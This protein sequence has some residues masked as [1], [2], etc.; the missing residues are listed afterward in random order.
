MSSSVNQVHYDTLI[1]IAKQLHSES[2]DH[3]RL[4][5]QTRQR[6]DALQGGGWQGDAAKAFFNEMN[7]ELLPAS[8]R[9]VG[10]LQT[11][12]SVLNQIMQIIHQADEETASNFKKFDAY[13]FERREQLRNEMQARYDELIKAGRTPDT[14]DRFD[15]E[16][17]IGTVLLNPTNRKAI[18]DMAKKYGIDPALLTG[19]I[20]V[21]MDLDYKPGLNEVQDILGRHFSPLKNVLDAGLSPHIGDLAGK[22]LASGGPGVGNV[23]DHSLAYAIQYL[24]DNHLPGADA[25]QKYDWSPQNR[26]SFNGSVE[27]AAIVLSMYSHMHGGASSVD[28]MAVIWGAY[29]SGIEGVIPSDS[30]K[31][32]GKGYASILDFQNNLANGAPDDKFKMGTNAYYAQP[33]FQL[34]REALSQ[35]APLSQ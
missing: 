34:F 4:N 5:A 19:T 12:E 2:E 26:S 21:E 9:L 30:D 13:S 22:L 16:E 20:A 6:M 14:T 17:A 28:D 18:D 33:Y 7:G 25:A 1:Q 8:Q 11:G 29:K 15:S 24:Q 27:G 32:I 10:A 3:A 31:G 35:P 23:H